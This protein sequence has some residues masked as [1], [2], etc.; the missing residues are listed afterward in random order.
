MPCTRPPAGIYPEGQSVR[1]APGGRRLSSGQEGELT[2]G[3]ASFF[4]FQDQLST[5]NKWTHTVTS[6]HVSQSFLKITL[7]ICL[8]L[9]WVL[10]VA[11]AFLELGRAGLLSR[12]GAR[13]SRRG[14][15][16]CCG[17]LRN[18]GSRACGLR[19]LC[20]RLWS[21]GPCLWRVGFVAL[22]PVGSARSG[23]EPVSPASSAGGIFTAEPP[24]KPSVS[25]P[26]SYR[27]QALL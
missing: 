14:G 27:P 22:R 18:T 26:L 11:P 24:G 12:C 25:Q 8:W 5:L 16:S 13:P 19:Q 3:N 6:F 4:L 15:F 2:C 7:F 10:A 9:C 23:T 20:S 1:W 21:A 17:T